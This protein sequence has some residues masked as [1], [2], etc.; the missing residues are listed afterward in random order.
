MMPVRRNRSRSLVVAI[1][2]LALVFAGFEGRTANAMLSPE[3]SC[4]PKR[5]VIRSLDIDAP[6]EVNKIVNGQM[7]DASS[8]GV[9]SW[10]R[11]TA[12]PGPYDSTA[13]KYGNAV[14]SGWHSRSGSAGVL[15]DLPSINVGAVL[16]VTC[17][18]GIRH[19]YAVEW[20][21][22]VSRDSVDAVTLQEVVGRSNYSALTLIGGSGHNDK[23]TG[24]DKFV[25]IA[26]AR[27]TGSTTE[28][29]KATATVQ[30][31]ASSNH[32]S[33]RQ[34]AVPASSPD[35]WT[36]PQYGYSVTWNREWVSTDPPSTTTFAIKHGSR[37]IIAGYEAMPTQGIPA[38]IMYDALSAA[39][40]AGM[41]EGSQRLSSLVDA[42]R[43]LLAASFG[44]GLFI[45]EIYFVDNGQTMVI[46]TIVVADPDPERAI[47]DY[48]ESV[49][50]AGMEPLKDWA[51]ISH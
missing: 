25:L 8:V 14:M 47:S 40:E 29:E 4:I 26:R 39:F 28:Q 16:N 46:S 33:K 35:S 50:V 17:E 10:Y 38:V 34:D 45:Q 24:E 37:K 9:V 44:P 12:Y 6:I 15:Y 42:N 3:N 13:G 21:K 31:K 19:S 49:T 27:F 30:A 36:D 22:L 48:R 43:I 11:E 20:V 7:L 32:S 41:P 51:R 1:L 5:L 18:G 2:C 23:V